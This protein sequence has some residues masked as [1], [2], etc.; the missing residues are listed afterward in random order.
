MQDTLNIFV[1]ETELQYLALLSIKHLVDN[2]SESIIFT[3]SPRVYE[4]LCSEQVEC[5]LV[6]RQSSG[7]IGRLIRIRKNLHLYLAAIKSLGHTF[8]QIHLHVPRI[9]NVHNNIAIHFLKYHLPSAQI[10][11]RLIP[12]GAINI[13]SCA[14]SPAKIKKQKR[15]AKN[16]GFRLFPDMKF[17]QYSGDELGADSDIVDKI[18]SFEGME[19][20]YPQHKICNIRLPLTADS[21]TVE[22]NAALVIGQN[23]L[24]LKTA[25][26]SFIDSV[27]EKIQSLVDKE[28]VSRIDY[29][30]HPRSEFDEFSQPSYQRLRDEYL[31]VEEHIAKGDYKYVISC[32]SSALIN[33][34]IMLGDEINAISV[35]LGDF[36]FSDK[37]QSNKLIES[38]KKL[39]IE[40]IN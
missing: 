34:K 7:W 36:P 14:L 1:I 11:V 35:G 16:I 6:S 31:C 25:S 38:Y 19:T 39:G 17:M 23:F 20:S 29:A 37:S 26:K 13:F 9:D 8:S 21:S 32:Y 22:K 3:T 28:A 15:W 24:Q 2:E 40:V 10:N 18:F 27:S 5:H 30:P 33:S 4:R 12:D